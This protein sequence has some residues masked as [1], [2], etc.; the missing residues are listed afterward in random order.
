MS[1][2][3]SALIGTLVASAFL[4]PMLHLNSWQKKQ[5]EGSM[6]HIEWAVCRVPE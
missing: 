4:L 5:Q 2:I 3:L 1:I 6:K